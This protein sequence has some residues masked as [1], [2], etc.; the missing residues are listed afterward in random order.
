VEGGGEAINRQ[1]EVAGFYAGDIGGA[2]RD[3]I[4]N[5]EL[6]EIFTGGGDG[7]SAFFAIKSFIK[8][9]VGLQVEHG[10]RIVYYQVEAVKDLITDDAV[11]ILDPERIGGAGDILEVGDNVGDKDFIHSY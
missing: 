1:D 5:G 7:E 6:V 9:G 3:D 8:V 4:M 10:I 2:I 11:A